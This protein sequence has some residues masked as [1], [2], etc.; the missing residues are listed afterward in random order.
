MRG[1]K[2]AEQSDVGGRE[3]TWSVCAQI[4]RAVNLII[5]LIYLRTV[6]VV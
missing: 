2:R 4:L 3:M 6:S 5:C 1:L